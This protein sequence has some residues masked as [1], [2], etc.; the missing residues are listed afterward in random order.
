M[1]ELIELAN[2][3][4]QASYAL[5]KAGSAK[6]DEA[7]LKI[8]ELLREN[9]EEIIAQNEIDLQNAREKGIAPSMLD[10]L[11]LTKER[12]CAIADGVMQ[13]R[14]LPD[15]VGEVISMWERPNGLKIGQ[16]RVPLGVIGII[17]EARPNV[18]VDAAALCLKASNT[19]ILRGGSEAIHSNMAL[20]KVMRDALA[21]VGLPQDCICL[22]ED[23]SRAVAT[24]MMQ[25]N[26]YIDVLIPR[27]GAGLIRSVVE[28][29]TVPVIETGTGQLPRLCPQR[30]RHGYGAQ[31]CSQREGEPP[32]GVQRG[33]KL[34]H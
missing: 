6:K 11:A 9:T 27:G 24:Q 32:V 23:T 3:A 5:A 14:S 17:Y 10:R 22:V 31:Y 33:G 1:R 12:I 2:G 26:G 13:V 34:S 30:V 20:T 7:L 21:Q 18:T 15:P 28:N 8:S 4:K 19:V 29:A 25:L 16:K